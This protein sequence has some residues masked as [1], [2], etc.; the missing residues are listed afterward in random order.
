MP[1][2][3]DRSGSPTS[4][5]R[6]ARSTSPRAWPDAGAF[7]RAAP[8]WFA[9]DRTTGQR[10]ALYVACEKDTLRAQLTGWLK[11]TGIPVLVVRGFGS[12]SYAQVVRERTAWRCSRERGAAFRQQFGRRLPLRMFQERAAARW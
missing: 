9:L 5:T 2:P 4:S 11:R 10:T 7:L 6:C 12:Q 8:D 3:D 1:R